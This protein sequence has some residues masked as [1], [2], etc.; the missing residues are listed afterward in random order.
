MAIDRAARAKR[1]QEQ[2]AAAR[3]EVEPRPSASAVLG[4]EGLFNAGAKHQLEHLAWVEVVK[5]DD[6]ESGGPLDLE[7]DVVRLDPRD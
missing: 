7:S 2:R 3:P 6:R 5:E 1:R 4:V